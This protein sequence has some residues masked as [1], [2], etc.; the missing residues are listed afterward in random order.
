MSTDREDGGHLIIPQTSSLRESPPPLKPNCSLRRDSITHTE[1][2]ETERGQKD[3]RYMTERGQRHNGD[4][5]VKTTETTKN[6]RVDRE[7]TESGKT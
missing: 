1:G 4:T 6:N 5:M 2:P 7:R 3:D